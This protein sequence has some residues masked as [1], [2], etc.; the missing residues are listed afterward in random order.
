MLIVLITATLVLS[1]WFLIIRYLAV[2]I[3]KKFVF[4]QTK[5]MDYTLKKSIENGS[6]TQQELDGF[7][8]T[9]FVIDSE[10]GYELSGVYQE[11][12]DPSKAVIFVHGHTWSWHGQ[13]KYFYLYQ[14]R[15]YTIIA[16]NLR[17][18]GDSGG[19]N[20]SAGYFEKHD[21]DTVV[22]W[23]RT[24][25]PDV[26]TLGLMG[27]SLGGATVL[28][29][30]PLAKDI[31]FIHADCPF[32]S[33][34]KLYDYQLTLRNI[35]HFM[36]IRIIEA[37]RSYI[38]KKAGFDSFEVEPEQAITKGNMPILL[39][40]GEADRYVPSWMSRHMYETRKEQ[41]PTYCT[42]IPDAV[43]AQS[44]QTDRTR[45]EEAVNEFLNN[46]E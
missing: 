38:L 11:G 42:L 27:E 18:H 29:Y 19:E 10:Y 4:P 45:Y 1:A 39:I 43:H 9:P 26:K 12:S 24:R 20:C 3:S 32:S 8:L 16:Y 17:A 6:F 37:S 46:S 34:R 44:L 15:G 23:A 2:R 40:H 14:R 21:L 13:V 35:P 28:Q 25:F 33:M 7:D 36:R 30:V 22:R 5:N 31:S 41:A